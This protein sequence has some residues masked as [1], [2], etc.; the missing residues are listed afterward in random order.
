MCRIWVEY[1]K[2]QL[3]SRM[4]RYYFDVQVL[5]KESL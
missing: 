5:T 1:P 3:E 2:Q 4:I